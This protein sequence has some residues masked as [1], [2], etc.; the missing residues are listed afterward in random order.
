MGE[1]L[2]NNLLIENPELAKE[3]HPTRN[4]VLTPEMATSGSDKKV[5]WLGRCGHEWQAN[6]G[7]D[8][9][10]AEADSCYID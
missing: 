1:L 9:E 7:I 8:A 4:D 2:E 10:V 3:W 5:W 6:M